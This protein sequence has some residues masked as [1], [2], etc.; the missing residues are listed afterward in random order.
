MNISMKNAFLKLVLIAASFVVAGCGDQAQRDAANYKAGIEAYSQGNYAVALEKLKPVAEH[1]NAQAQN[2]LGVM[3]SQGQGVA[4]NDKEAG[5]WWGKAAEQGHVEAQESLGLLYAKGQGVA[6]DWV[7]AYKWFS[8]AGASG[9]ETALNNQKVIGVHMSPEKIA[10]ANALAQEW[11]E[12][13]K[14]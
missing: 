3:H 1:G 4:R 6:Q 12:K 10:E 14:R 9:K 7:Q 2:K 13:H 5:V 11:L 8:I